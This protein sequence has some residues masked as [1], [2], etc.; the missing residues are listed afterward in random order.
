M[1]AKVEIFTFNILNKSNN[2]VKIKFEDEALKEI[3]KYLKKNIPNKVNQFP[4]GKDKKTFKID[5][6][7][8]KKIKRKKILL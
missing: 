7:I 5:T 6:Y 8:D 3:F 2:D 1:T 4:P